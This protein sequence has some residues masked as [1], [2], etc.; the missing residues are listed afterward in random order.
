MMTSCSV[1]RTVRSC[2]C[3]AQR[4]VDSSSLGE[5]GIAMSDEYRRVTLSNYEWRI[6]VDA[7]RKES[8]NVGILR[9]AEM[10]TLADWIEWKGK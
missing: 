2:A 4:T 1:Q 5:R 3:G 8:Q 6:V 7:L 10:Q 9:R